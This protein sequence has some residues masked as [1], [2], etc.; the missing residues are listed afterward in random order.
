MVLWLKKR[1]FLAKTPYY[2]RNIIQR[3]KYKTPNIAMIGNTMVIIAAMNI[4]EISPFST[5]KEC[6]L[7]LYFSSSPY[8]SL[9]CLRFSNIPICSANDKLQNVQ[10]Q[11]LAIQVLLV[12]TSPLHI[13]NVCGTYT[14]LVD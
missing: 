2:L 5:S 13:Y 11:S 6:C 3:T 4:A 14:L 1:H 7:S 12:Y 9:M 8:F 10:V